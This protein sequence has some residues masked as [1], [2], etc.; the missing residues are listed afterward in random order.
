[1]C[2]CVHFL[3]HAK[4]SAPIWPAP[5]TGTFRWHTTRRQ[6]QQQ[7]EEERQQQMAE[8]TPYYWFF[9]A[10]LMHGTVQMYKNA[11]TLMHACEFVQVSLTTTTTRA[12][13]LLLPFCLPSP[14]RFVSF[15]FFFFCSAFAFCHIAKATAPSLCVCVC[16]WVCVWPYGRLL[17][18]LHPCESNCLVSLGFIA[19]LWHVAMWN[20]QVKIK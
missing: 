8:K 2:V 1:M 16:V 13:L 6:Q 20:L 3:T 14:I 18:W 9:L 19:D 15:C 17:C 10:L 11:L 7:E 12:T 5:L 4:Y